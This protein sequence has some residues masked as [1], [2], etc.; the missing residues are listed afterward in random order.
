MA[1]ALGRKGGQARARRLPAHEKKRIA[2]MGGRA[3]LA[4][5]QAARRII[6]NLRY[7]AAVDALRGAVPV[8]R[9]AT[10]AGPL[11]GIDRGSG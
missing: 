6:E 1:K 9:R 11:P 5:L 7:A 3:R 10:F 8:T 2:S 4:S